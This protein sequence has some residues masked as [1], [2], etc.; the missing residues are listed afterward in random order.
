MS[1]K[2]RDIVRQLLRLSQDAGATE[3][4]R[5]TA[6][7]KAA[8]LMQKYAIE[9]EQDADTGEPVIRG[10]WV[11]GDW[12]EKWHEFVANGVAMIYGCR[13]VTGV[14]RADG[15]KTRKAQGAFQ[16]VGRPN[17]IEAAEETMRWLFE[18][19]EAEWKNT[20]AIIRSQP[21]WG[22]M[23]ESQR[24]EIRCEMRE[25]FKAGAG[26]RIFERAEA[27]MAAMRGETAKLAHDTSKALAIIDQNLA[28]A[29]ALLTDCKSLTIRAPTSGLGTKLG[30]MAGDR[31]ELQKT[32]GDNPTNAPPGEVFLIEDKRTS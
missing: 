11:H 27:I 1:D 23:H 2:I 24:K 16:F 30:Q 14:G 15:R 4:E 13:V 21:V 32:M 28:E 5:A 6:A 17:D 3:A 12:T 10:D 25:T 19:I 7:A 22:Q 26:V 31:L 20:L 8:D 18:Q 9:V 29:D